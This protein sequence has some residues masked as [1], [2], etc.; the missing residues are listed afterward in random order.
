MKEF[1]CVCTDHSLVVQKFNAFDEE[2]GDWSDHDEFEV[3]I[4][5]CGTPLYT[6]RDRLRQIWHIIRVGHPYADSVILSREN[7]L[8]LRNYLSDVTGEL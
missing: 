2:K 7:A 6:I 4:W 8:A 5:R 3:A 1:L